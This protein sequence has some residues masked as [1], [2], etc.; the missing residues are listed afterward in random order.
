MEVRTE[1]RKQLVVFSVIGLE[2]TCHC[3]LVLETD[4]PERT[5]GARNTTINHNVNTR[6]ERAVEQDPSG[7]APRLVGGG[8]EPRPPMQ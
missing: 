8:D 2:I 3:A 1:L 4:D 5:E 7:G 6:R